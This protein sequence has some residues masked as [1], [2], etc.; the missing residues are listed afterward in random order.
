MSRSGHDDER[1]DDEPDAQHLPP[2]SKRKRAWKLGLVSSRMAASYLGNKVANVF[3]NPAARVDAALRTHRRNAE[4]LAE[5]MGQLKGA[6]MKVGQLLSIQDGAL[7][8]AFGD[9]LGRFHAQAPP[10]HFRFVRDVVE[11]QLGAPLEQL[12]A[13]FEPQ[14][15]AAASLG[16]V[17]RARRHDGRLVAVKVQ[18]PG[19]EET[20]ESD[21][22][23]LRKVVGSLR[24]AGSSYDLSEAYDEVRAMLLR[25]ADY[26]E[27]ARAVE[28]FASRLQDDPDVVVPGVHHDRSSLRVLT[29]DYLE[30]QHLDAFVE[31]VSD[32]EVRNRVG[33]KLAMVIWRLEFCHGLLHAD[34]HPGNYL[35]L[36]DERLGLLDFGCVKEFSPGF[37]T[38]YRSAIAAILRRDDEALLDAFIA[39]RF[40]QPEERET[41]RARA[42]L[43]WTYL[44]SEP[45]L[46]EGVWEGDWEAFIRK[47]HEQ[48]NS[49]ALRLGFRM[50]KEAVFLNRVLLGVMC[51]WNRLNVRLDWN[52]MIREVLAEPV[53]GAE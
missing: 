47:L 12:F 31:T 53:T 4:R 32:P 42:Y 25:E 49:M 35:F 1:N 22:A 20:I 15:V 3:R 8:S 43:D 14:P 24:W 50:P 29:L 48:L 19:I 37:L 41:E 7:P 5:T 17:H 2:T 6:V 39:M 33:R 38:H 23:N 40:L 16:Q 30:G 9:V 11:E 51:F 27:E 45:L 34:P 18:Y 46:H 44:S 28:L 13:A 36:P 21:L 52:A 10:M 26:T